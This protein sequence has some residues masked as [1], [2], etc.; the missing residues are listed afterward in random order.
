MVRYYSFI[1]RQC[2]PALRYRYSVL[3]FHLL[4]VFIGHKDTSLDALRKPHRLAVGDVYHS[5]PAAALTH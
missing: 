5:A 1:F 2:V 3:R 4:T